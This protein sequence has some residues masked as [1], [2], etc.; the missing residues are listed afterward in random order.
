MKIF[1]SVRYKVMLKISLC[2][3]IVWK[4]VSRPSRSSMNVTRTRVVSRLG[5]KKKKKLF[6]LRKSKIFSRA[7]GRSLHVAYCVSKLRSIYLFRAYTHLSLFFFPFSFHTATRTLLHQ[8]SRIESK[9]SI[10]KSMVKD[11]RSVKDSGATKN[12]QW[13]I[14]KKQELSQNVVNCE[15]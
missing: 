10:R 9:F 1:P 2:K 5:L 6:N 14:G 12:C 3:V 7:S 4:L 11:R 8:H 13:R 15:L